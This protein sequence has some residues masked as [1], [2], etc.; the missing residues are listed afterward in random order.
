M[1][2]IEIIEI[3]AYNNYEGVLHLNFIFSQRFISKFNAQFNDKIDP[4]V[5]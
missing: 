5:R 3:I 4:R 2:T 1:S